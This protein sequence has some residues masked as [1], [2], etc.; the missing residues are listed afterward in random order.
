M[1]QR[2]LYID[3]DEGLTR[4]LQK[5]LGRRG[6][7]VTG[8]NSADAGLARLAAEEFDVVALDH[9][10]PGRGGL[11]TLAEVKALP[12]APPVVYVTGS[13][14]AR[15]AVAALKAGASDY[16][17]KAIGDD[18]FD[19]LASSLNHALERQALIEARLAAEAELRA[20]NERL[21]ALVREANHRV[22]NSL[23][24]VA[25][26]IQIQA[27][28]ISTPEALT[29]L[30]DTRQ[31][32]QTISRLHRRLYTTDDIRTIEL[33]EYLQTV[34]SDLE[35][36]W[37]TDAAPRVIRF[38]AEPIRLRTDH[39]VSVG[40]VVN[41]LVSNACKYA[42]P[43]DAPGEI[44]VTLQRNEDGFQIAI[45]DDGVGFIEDAAPTGTGI[46]TK[47]VEAMARSL[48]ATV[49]YRTSDGARVLLTV[50]QGE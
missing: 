13:D 11:E 12:N 33:Q 45:E 7:D 5:A 22:A 25:S 39:A 2:V 19:L 27:N 37:S 50:P 40:V 23:Q 26:F 31:R 20:S 6:F 47:L 1:R 32:V 29:A 8:V 41:E 28:V 3:D 46:G 42:Y 24:I 18:F 16:V 17:L 44:R 9:T 48:S 30:K 49:D 4:L 34:L 43:N 36:A 10:M 15:V 21:A 38:T 14:D 35:A